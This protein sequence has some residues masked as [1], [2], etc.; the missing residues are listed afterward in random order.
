MFSK[1]FSIPLGKA[2]ELHFLKPFFFFLGS[3]VGRG[4]EAGAGGVGF[5]GSA[6]GREAGTGAGGATT[7]GGVGF[8]GVVVGRG[9]VAFLTGGGV[10]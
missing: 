5:L 2:R 7:A 3:A 6:V 1:N 9:G 8:L 4:A 10:G